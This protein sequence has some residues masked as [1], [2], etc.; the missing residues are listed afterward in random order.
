MV[1]RVNLRNMQAFTSL[2]TLSLNVPGAPIHPDITALVAIPNTD[3]YY[4]GAKPTSASVGL[5]IVTHSS[6]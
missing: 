6:T 1:V 5:V 3:A 2:Q 4:I